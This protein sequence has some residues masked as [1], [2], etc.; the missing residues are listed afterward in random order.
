MSEPAASE[1]AQAACDGM[2]RMLRPGA[3]LIAHPK[4]QTS[5]GG[6]VDSSGSGN[7][8]ARGFQSLAQLTAPSY[9][10]PSYQKSSS[11]R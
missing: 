9:T 1:A 2:L 10:R 4:K 3:L 6:A 5:S 7:Q 8:S 11:C